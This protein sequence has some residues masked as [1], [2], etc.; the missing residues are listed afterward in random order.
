V[1]A[2]AVRHRHPPRS[3]Q[4]MFEAEGT[5]LTEYLL[6]QRLAHAYRLLMDPGRAG[7]KIA[8]IAYDSGFGDLSYFNRAFRR[9]YGV[10]PS[11]LRAQTQARGRA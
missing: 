5:T 11:D 9:R 3:I 1:T 10:V 6:A 2:L 8:T 7:E 4:R